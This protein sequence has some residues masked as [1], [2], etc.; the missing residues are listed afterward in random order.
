[1]SYKTTVSR[2]TKQAKIS[3]AGGKLAHSM[4]RANK[5]PLEKQYNKLMS[6]LILVKQKLA[7]KYGKKAKMSVMSARQ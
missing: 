4:A 6:Q 3:R 5:D 2:N 7:A 1:M